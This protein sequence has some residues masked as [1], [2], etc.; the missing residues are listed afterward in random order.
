MYFRVVHWDVNNEELHGSF[1]E[2]KTGDV[3]YL[4]KAFQMAHAR[5]SDVKLF[6]ND[7]SVVGS[8]EST[9]VRHKYLCGYYTFKLS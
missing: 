8:G 9:Q 4:V 6:L 5:D 2:N 3:D 1:F 7:Y